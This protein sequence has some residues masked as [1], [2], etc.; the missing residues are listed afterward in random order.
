MNRTYPTI[1]LIQP[2][3]RKKRGFEGRIVAPCCKNDTKR[4]G[5]NWFVCELL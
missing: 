5:I 3:K 1:F 4:W 2:W